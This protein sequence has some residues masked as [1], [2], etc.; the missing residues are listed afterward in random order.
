MIEIER[1]GERE[2]KEKKRRNKSRR[3]W[4][5]SPC[6]KPSFRS[7]FS[8]Q[9]RLRTEGPSTWDCMKRR[10]GIVL[11]FHLRGEP[12]GRGG[13]ERESD[14]EKEEMM[15]MMQANREE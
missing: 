4:T 6:C 7:S 8:P 2:E 13:G 11:R 15:T 1:E 14:G 3:T 9:F 12:P 5:S 10:R